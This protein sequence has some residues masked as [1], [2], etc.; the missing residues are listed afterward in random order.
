MVQ[1]VDRK[2]VIDGQPRLLFSGELHY[3]RLL[4][5][6]WEDRILKAKALGCS[7]I[8]SYIPWMIHESREG[9]FDL[10]GKYAPE[11]YLG[12]F[13]DLVHKHGLY[14][15][16]RPGPFVMAEMKHEGIPAWVYKTYPEVVPQTWKGEKKIHT[17]TV[18]YLSPHFLK[19]AERW[20]GQVMP[21]LAARLQPKGGPVIGIQLDNE[22]GMLSWVCNE[23]DLGEDTLCDFA[24]WLQAHYSEHELSKRYPFSLSDPWTR[25]RAIQ[26]PAAG[27]SAAFLR[28]Y[29]D[30][31][32]T[33]IAK[34][35]SHL[36]HYAEQAGI[37]GIPFIINIHGSGG[38]RALAFPIGIHHLF[39]AYTQD[40]NYLA[41]SDHY[42]GDLGRQNASD[43]YVLNAFM[44]AVSRPEQPL[45]SMEFEVGSGDY[46]ENGAVRNGPAAADF[47]VRLCVAQGNRLI[48]YYSLA[49][50][51]NPYLR[52]RIGDGNDRVAFTGGRH[53]FAAPISPEG[54]LDRTYFSLKATTQTMLMHAEV[55]AD[56]EEELD[57]VSLAFIPDYY[58]TDMRHD[59]PIEEIVSGLESYREV[60]DNISRMMVALGLRFDAVDIQRRKPDPAKALVYA[61]AKYLD[62]AEQERLVE[63]IKGGGRLLICFELP[64][65]D[66]EGKPCTIL[67]DALGLRPGKFL[68]SSPEWTL[69]VQGIGWANFEPEVSRWQVRAYDAPKGDVFMRVV[70]DH[71]PCGVEVSLGKGVA[72]VLGTNYVNHMKFYEELFNRIQV[73]PGVTHDDATYGLVT[74]T[75]KSSKGDRFLTVLNLDLESK[76]VH[77][78]EHGRPLFGGKP[79]E[80]GIREGK[81]LPLG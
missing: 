57:A 21:L 50:G 41:G 40:S 37:E 54:E 22:M 63:Y 26:N 32:R 81:L 10:T 59:G 45:A 9:D 58:K 69:A 46:G 48:N 31:R 71:S 56:S 62:K 2:I 30:F 60:L 16:G 20:Y 38:G 28:D 52:D 80:L 72:V 5:S 77:F 64:V 18:Q 7:T 76:A 17:A 73:A 65:L 44:K 68:Q 43:L 67:S 23:P 42:L 25:K 6:E 36:R 66:M 14:F 15:I 24:A 78:W 8:A 74:T 61:G 19:L 12:A 49:G 33:Y 29:E 4:R 34:Y 70:G 79:I 39:E 11:N 3:F 55:L 53:G 35:V 47:T 51:H 1:L 13:I 75:T 27:Y